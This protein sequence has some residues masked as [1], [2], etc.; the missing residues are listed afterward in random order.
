MK[1]LYHVI[2]HRPQ[3]SQTWTPINIPFFLNTAENYFGSE[4]AAQRWID[5]DMPNN[6]R[7][8]KVIG[9]VVPVEFKIG[10]VVIDEQGEDHC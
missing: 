10:R 7:T 5:H 4:R 2:L 9:G 6:Y 3:G 1:T 8:K